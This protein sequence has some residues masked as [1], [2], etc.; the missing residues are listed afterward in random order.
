MLTESSAFRCC[1]RGGGGRLFKLFSLI[2]LVHLPLVSNAQQGCLVPAALRNPQT[3]LTIRADSQQKIRGIYSLRGHVLITYRE[4]RLQADLVTYND[5]TGQ[6]DARGHVVFDDPRGHLEAEEAHYNVYTDKGWFSNAH[7]YLHAPGSR[8]TGTSPTALF[9]RAQKIVRIDSDTYSAQDA[10]VSSCKKEDRGL[11]FALERAKLEIGHRM[12]GH[13]AVF[14]FIGIPVFYLPF[15]TVSTARQPRQSGFLLPRIGESTQKGFVIG[16]GF[17]W[18]IN[19][20][21]DLL[22]G[23]ENFSL[24][25]LGF[26]GR[27]RARP[28]ATSKIT[29]NFFAIDDRGSGALRAVRAPGGSFDVVGESDN[30][31]GGFRGVVNAGYVNSLAFRTTWSDNFNTA[32]FSEARQTGFATKS[33]GPYSINFYA[34]RY[35]D[36]LSA[37]TVNEQSIIIR[38]APSFSFSS[39]DQQLGRTPLY[40]SL[41][42]SLEGV[43]RSQ[44]GYF[45]PTLSERLDFSP[46]VTLRTHPFWGFHLTPTFGVRETYY[47]TSLKPDQSATNRFLGDVSVDLRPPSFEKV[48]SRT[49][50]GRRFKHVIEPDIQYHLVKASDPANIFDI[51]RYDATDILTDDNELEYSLTNS[52]LERKASPN[53]QGTAPQARDLLSWTLTQKY[54]FDPTFGGTVRPGSQIAI[55]PTLDL[56]GFAFPEGRRLS[57]L[58][59]VLKFSP[60]SKV[61]AEFRTDFDPQGGGILNAGIT[62]RLQLHALDLA[63]TDFFINRTVYLPAPVAPNVP[64]ISLPTF[65]LLNMVASHGN[66]NHKGLTEAF[67]VD[68]NLSQDIAEDFVGQVSYNFGC[69]ALNAQ[70]ERF[71]LGFIRNENLFRLSITLGNIGTFGSLKPGQF[72]QRQLSQIP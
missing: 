70:F 65:N 2:F 51:V 18:N 26:S 17:F 67:R 20:S 64:L 40:F 28:S 72:L 7:G 41:D 12:T 61:D 53:S 39:V 62:S 21:A 34:S 43:G 56:T 60:T 35:Q 46:R 54:F 29:A 69:F 55:E 44:P 59:S 42:T 15:V 45:G 8:Q 52:I 71:N 37:A 4:M 63:L 22:L 48:F 50:F 14:C 33:F 58:D 3:T 9:M 66:I 13:E 30:L 1:L 10:H 16:D 23:L 31:G 25:G 27:F 32:V 47:G 38:Q 11:A 19:P 24:R 5:S 36:F 49:F 57:P 6:V 68:Y